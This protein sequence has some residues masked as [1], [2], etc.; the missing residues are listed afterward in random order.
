[1]ST[2]HLFFVLADHLLLPMASEISLGRMTFITRV[3]ASSCFI[4]AI[5]CEER[6]SPLI[7]RPG[8]MAQIVAAAPGEPCRAGPSEC[9]SGRGRAGA[10]IVRR[11][12]DE[13]LAVGPGPGVAETTTDSPALAV[14][15]DRSP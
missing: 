4:G 10:R 6:K 9:R 1:M 13:L 3:F 2:K 5:F 12:L 7:R 8:V 15:R 11:L 14:R